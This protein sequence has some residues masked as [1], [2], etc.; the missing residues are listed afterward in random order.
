MVSQ[1]IRNAIPAGLK[2]KPCLCPY[3]DFEINICQV[4]GEDID[5]EYK[6]CGINTI[7]EEN[8][9]RIVLKEVVLGVAE[10]E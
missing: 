2:C 10:K 7:W 3:Y 5:A 1:Q 8:K 6:A 4:M 9:G